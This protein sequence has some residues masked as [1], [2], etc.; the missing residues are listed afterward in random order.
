MPDAKLPASERGRRSTVVTSGAEEQVADVYTVG[1]WT[2]KAR[3]EAEFVAA[4][5]AM[6]EATLV[7]E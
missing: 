1:I 6:G 4:W 3:R 5:Q 2:V 7:E